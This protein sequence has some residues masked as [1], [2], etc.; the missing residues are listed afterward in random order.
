MKPIQI[1]LESHHVANFIVTSAGRSFRE[2]ESIARWA[3][4]EFGWT[5]IPLEEFSGAG[6]VV[7]IDGEMVIVYNPKHPKS[8]KVII[9]EIA[10]MIML[11][12]EPWLW[13]EQAYHLN[14][15]PVWC[16]HKIAREVEK[17]IALL[18]DWPRD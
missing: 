8:R 6:A 5:F 10:E 2:A 7:S 13:E 18:W 11:K 12:N 17:I 9:H 16:R 15:N 14:G 1:A 4:L 3:A